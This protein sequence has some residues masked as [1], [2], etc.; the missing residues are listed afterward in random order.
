M[1]KM[2]RAWKV[3]TVQK[4][5]NSPSSGKP[6]TNSQFTP[7]Q[8]RVFLCPSVFLLFPMFDIAAIHITKDTKK[9]PQK[10]ALFF[11]WVC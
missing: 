10:G 3:K 4:A 1:R 5:A 7:P 2:K 11:G 9:R 8:W 6:L